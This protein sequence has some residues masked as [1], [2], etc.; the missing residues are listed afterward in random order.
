MQKTFWSFVAALKK[1]KKKRVCEKDKQLPG[2]SF[3]AKW[4]P[5][6]LS[7]DRQVNELL[8]RENVMFIRLVKENE[9]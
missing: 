4:E 6:E 9:R 3:L 1:K 2:L 7:Q 8:K 5:C